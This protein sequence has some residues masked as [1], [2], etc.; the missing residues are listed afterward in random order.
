M[1]PTALSFV[2]IEATGANP[3]TGRIIEIGI[4]RVENNQLIKTYKTLIN[5]QRYIEPFIQN[6]TG[7]THEALENAPTFAQVKDEI[8]EVLEGSI[9]VAHNV[10]FDYGFL[11]NEFKRFDHSF[12]LKHFC[13]VKLARLLYP[14]HQ[15]YNLDSIIERFNIVCENRHRAFDDAK[16][17]WEFYQKAFQ[18]IPQDMFAKA[19]SIALKRSSIPLGI[20]QE[21]LDSLPQ[22]PGV[23]IF[24]GENGMPLYIGKSV[25]VHGR[26]LSHFSSDHMSSTEMKIAQQ[27]TNIETFSTAGELGALFLESTLIKK[28][29][30]LFNRKLRHARKL[31]ALK[32]II[33]TGGYN[34]IEE[35]DGNEVTIDV[36]GNIVGI[37]TSQKQV[38]DFLYELCKIYGLCPKMFGLEKGKGACFSYQLEKCSGACVGKV[39][40]LK[41]NLKFDEAF[42]QHRIKPWPFKGPIMIKEKGDPLDEDTKHEH[43]V[44]DKWCLIG[45]M[46]IEQDELS[47]IQQDYQF[48]FD[49]YKI[50]RSYLRVERN[51]HKVHTLQVPLLSS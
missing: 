9:F 22:T 47:D 12:S 26:V 10:R 39:S 50:L 45:S 21:K 5:P 19:V 48:D 31:I 43:F 37:F 35:I 16:V 42:Y 17:L 7:I 18:E 46:K 51:L 2:D 6:L 25:N 32:K 14:G 11:R 13:T 4:L 38:K 8:I 3:V 36:L 29:Q 15:R 24:Y 23:Y 33:T 40:P 1:L 34:T 41:Y 30:P 28:Q 44:V 20:S 49:T 27:V